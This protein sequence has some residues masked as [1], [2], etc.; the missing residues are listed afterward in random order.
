MFALRHQ[1]FQRL[2]GGRPANPQ[3]L[4]RHRALRRR[5]A[6]GVRP[7]AAFSKL[8]VQ[9][10]AVRAQFRLFAAQAL[11]RQQ[12]LFQTLAGQLNL[13]LVLLAL[14]GQLGDFLGQC[15]APGAR[16]FR[17]GQGRF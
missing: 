10:L 3:G 9:S 17:L 12:R 15:R 7:V 14:D 6:G 11:Q 16:L 8:L 5:L 2:R 13:L 4:Q 1:P